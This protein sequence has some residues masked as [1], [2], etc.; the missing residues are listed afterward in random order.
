[1]GAGFTGL[2]ASHSKR[3]YPGRRTG[4]ESATSLP[5]PLDEPS[6]R[7]TCDLRPHS[8][9]LPVPP[10]PE[11]EYEAL[12]ADIAGR[13]ICTPLEITANGLVMDGCE[14]LRA[15]I[16]L[17]IERVPVNVLEVGDERVHAILSL[18][19]RKHLDPAQRAV[20]AIELVDVR[21]RRAL[22][23]ER[24]RAN[25]GESAERATLPARGRVR[26]QL[27]GLSGAGAR[28]VEDV[29]T[30]YER[31]PDLYEELKAGVIAAHKAAR[32]VRQRELAEQVGEAPP[33][34]DGPFGL[35][36]AD[37]P[38]SSPN[39]DSEWAP[40]NHYPTMSQRELKSFSTDLPLAD[41]C[42]LYLW[43]LGCQLPQAFEVIEA[44]GFRY[45][46]DMVWVKQSIGLGRWVRYRHEHLLI[47]VRGGI[48]PP[49][50]ELRP[51]SVIEARRRRHSQKPDEAY[52]LIEKAYRHLPKLE[53]FARGKARPGWAAWGNQAEA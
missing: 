39:P 47:A 23:D 35:V 12:R 46:A 52:E 10:T 7:R 14:R 3:R 25:L 49:P 16:E 22:A 32:R 21:E 13:G 45:V 37:P 31:D 6:R 30:V 5:S 50:P 36:C 34:P 17:G 27:A 41:D 26:D 40:E 44:W 48:S 2:M 1:M 9:E 4:S 43:A 29:L 51:D 8:F 28:T 38:W 24:R 42:V 33:L 53:L 19:R 15:A 11:K 18:L 20:V